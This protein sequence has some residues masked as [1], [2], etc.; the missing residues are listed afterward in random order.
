[1]QLL[2]GWP[3]HLYRGRHPYGSFAEVR[4]P[5]WAV[6]LIGLVVGVPILLF[7]PVVEILHCL[8][9]IAAPLALVLMGAVRNVERLLVE[10]SIGCAQ[11]AKPATKDQ[12]PPYPRVVP[13]GFE[14]CTV[15]RSALDN[16]KSREWVYKSFGP[17][18]HV[19]NYS[20]NTAV[21]NHVCERSWPKIARVPAVVQQIVLCPAMQF[22][23]NPERTMPNFNKSDRPAKK[24]ES[25]SPK[26]AGGHSPNHRGF[27]PDAA[28][29]AKKRWNADERAART[30][31]RRPNWT[32]REERPAYNSDR[33]KRSF[34]DRAPRRSF[35]ERPPRRESDLYPSRRALILAPTREL[36]MQIDR[37]VQPIARSVGMF[38]T[39][40]DHAAQ[41][42]RPAHTVIRPASGAPGVGI[43]AVAGV[44]DDRG[45]H[46]CHGIRGI[47]F[48]ELWPFGDQHHG[49]RAA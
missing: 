8:I 4:A 33:P 47:E 22:R 40:I 7:G 25:R 5:L 11:P 41:Q 19:F 36:A 3:F 29:P 9:A 49:I 35:D 17:V 20:L 13:P 28:A 6:V 45:A 42:L 15:Y 27:R 21:K 43:Q 48:T 32:P 12:K 39:T 1:M 30:G 37:T 10:C 18:S 31:D 46:E 14:S 23:Y 26:A 24:Y 16:A 34:D 44:D 38:T 2:V